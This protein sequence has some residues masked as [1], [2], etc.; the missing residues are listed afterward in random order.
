[1]AQSVGLS[2]TRLRALFKSDLGLTPN[3]YVR[4]IK[5]EAA[6]EMVKGSYKRVN[7]IA[8]ELDVNDDSHFVRTFKK[9]YGMTPTQYRKLHQRRSEGDECEEH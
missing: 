1:M 3:Q 9:T 4:K 7:E 8:A 2:E 5:M 6:A